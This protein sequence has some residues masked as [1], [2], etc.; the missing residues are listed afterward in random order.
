MIRT[1]TEA[2]HP[3]LI[4]SD[5][6]PSLIRQGLQRSLDL[7][8]ALDIDGS[9]YIP[10]GEADRDGQHLNLVRDLEVAGMANEP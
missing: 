4:D 8:D 5:L 9:V 1:N 7:L 2:V 10:N 6:T 3:I